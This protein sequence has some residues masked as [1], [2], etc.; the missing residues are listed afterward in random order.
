MPS[1]RRAP[2]PNPTLRALLAET[3]WTQAAFALAIRR[4]AGEAGVP[5]RY[6]RA[7]VAHWLRGSRPRPAVQRFMAEALSR[8]LARPVTVPELGMGGSGGP[9]RPAPGHS[10]SEPR[11][12]VEGLPVDA[13]GR[14]LDSL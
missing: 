14:P 11:P 9:G 5:M 7:S 1:A 12:P 4:V 3:G 2:A 6:D 13:P 8:R 10:P